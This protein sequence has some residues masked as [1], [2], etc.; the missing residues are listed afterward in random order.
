MRNNQPVNDKEYVMPD[1]VLLASKTDLKGIIT[2]CN[3]D[4]IEAS[5]YSREELLGAPHNLVRHPDMPPEAFADLW[6]TL[7]QGKP[8]TGLVKNRRK[9]GGFYWVEANVTP[10]YEDEKLI[11]Y[12]S[13][14]YK[15][16]R[17]EIE[18]AESLYRQM[19]AGQCRLRLHEGQ[20]VSPGLLNS[21][22][23]WLGHTSV[24]LRL[25]WMV[26]MLLLSMAALVAYNLK[27]M[28]GNNALAVHALTMAAKQTA[29]VDTARRAQ[30]D[31]K[32]QIQEWKNLLLRGHD[33]EQFAKYRKKFD[34]KGGDVAANLQRLKP[35]MAELEIKTDGVDALLVAHA[36]LMD[37]YHNALASFQ[38]NNAG[39]S[40]VVDGLVKGMDRKPTELMGELVALVQQ[41]SQAQLDQDLAE[42]EARNSHYR[43]VSLVVTLALLL[44]GGITATF[45]LRGILK[46]LRLATESINQIMRGNY[47]VQIDTQPET[48]IGHML[49]AMKSMET[50]LGINVVEARKEADTNLRIKI[51]LDNVSTSVM[52]ADTDHRIIYMNKAVGELMRTAEADIRK[53]LPDFSA[54]SL[55]GSSFD[56]FH[57]NPG[58]QKALLERLEDTHHS[59]IGV[60]GRRFSLAASPVVNEYGHKLGTALEWKD[61]TTEVAVENEIA[62]IVEAAVQGNFTKRL[63]MQGKEGFF[64]KLSED[65]NH[66][67]DTADHGLQEVVRMLEALARGDLTDR[68]TNDYQGT[69][70]QL[71]D[72]AN[73]TAEKLNEII[74][75]IREA[76]DTIN[77]ASQEIAA[78]N[79]DLSQ[80]TEENASSLEQTASSMEELTSTVKQNAENAKQANQLALGA[81]DIAA[82]GGTVVGQVVTTMDSINESSRK[83]VDII[84][85]ID[86]IAFQTNILAL[87]AAVEAARAGEQG[88]GFAV[89][90]GEV[91]NLAQRSAAAAKEIKTLIGDSVEKVEGGSKLVAQA[92]QTMEEIVTSIKRVTDIMSEIAAASVEQS[93]GIEQVNLAITQMDE[94][95]QQNAALVEEAAAAAESLEEQAQNLSVAVATFK[96]DERVATPLAVRRAPTQA[97]PAR[98]VTPS[99]K[100]APKL[101]AKL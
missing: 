77:T 30:V 24:K 79:H 67:M 59:E 4:F 13:V 20:L 101:I 98:K 25:V 56:D 15:P 41:Q 78:G 99:R 47:H 74:G 89:V 88:R 51:G 85:V 29:A 9:D 96:V 92:G 93:A 46:P 28:S 19:R 54:D 16:G 26:A 83:I 45:I 86:G 50:V 52:I 48:E 12:M 11:G 87:N 64:R 100:A 22:N 21:L 5:G 75:Q 69:F 76:T 36:G 68:I 37:N 6:V 17:N 73:A 66:L 23:S 43:K 14:R 18:Q 7:K 62:Q 60:G 33:A 57:K 63:D 32:E 90:A 42:L 65:I 82:K 40:G 31:F 10:L 80:R 39:S 1:G 72:D 34:E 44:L 53:D 8:W 61:R 81:S 35:I 27:G 38:V 91:R 71:K 55:L 49:N 84:S 95:T 58:H 97:A 2:Y 70:G 3:D 94:V